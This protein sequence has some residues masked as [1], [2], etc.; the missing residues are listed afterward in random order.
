ME[1]NAILPMV[2][3]F[4]K[5][6]GCDELSEQAAA[7][8]AE[9][10]TG[11][12]VTDFAAT[13]T[14]ITRAI[15]NGIEAATAYTT[16]AMSGRFADTGS[17]LY[18]TQSVEPYKRKTKIELVDDADYSV[19]LVTEGKESE[20]V[21]VDASDMLAVS[22]ADFPTI[23][24]Y[25]TVHEWLKAANLAVAVKVCKEANLDPTSRHLDLS[26]TRVLLKRWFDNHCTVAIK[27]N[28][29]LEL[30]FEY[31]I[32][33]V[34]AWRLRTTQDYHFEVSGKGHFIPANTLGGTVHEPLLIS[35]KNV[36]IDHDSMVV[37]NSVV[38]D[39]MITDISVIRNA[40][41]IDCEVKDST[42]DVSTIAS[43]SVRHSYLDK[44]VAMDDTIVS[45]SLNNIV[46]VS[47]EHVLRRTI[48]GH[49]RRSPLV[50]YFN[51]YGEEVIPFSVEGVGSEEGTI[52]VGYCADGNVYISRGCFFG[53]YR[54]FKERLEAQ[55]Y[56]SKLDS[57]HYLNFVKY[58]VRKMEQKNIDSV[59][60]L[61][62]DMAEV[63]E[64]H[65]NGK[66]LI[67]D[68]QQITAKLSKRLEIV[69][70][71]SDKVKQSSGKE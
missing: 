4:T 30:R 40:T 5:Q 20:A 64:L 10:F 60:E 43:S 52:V 28:D 14:N 56:R 27:V 2:I 24:S 53:T 44:V 41:V 70:E 22:L 3:K 45:S 68:P 57:K 65:S 47:N 9:A 25:K 15:S 32:T 69:R 66:V 13:A 26:F 35:G 71:L 12:D 17:T 38:V 11:D 18:G 39:S 50:Y 8:I 61:V 36:W 63:N 19:R 1:E 34:F 51:S 54:E 23:P 37:S 29:C 59:R 42:V 58:L 31:H 48:S 21:V 7:K 49:F 6:E 33:G 46:V 62:R 67:E 16:H 55:S